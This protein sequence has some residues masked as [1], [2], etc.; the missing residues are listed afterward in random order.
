MNPDDLLEKTARERVRIKLRFLKFAT[1][2][3]LL[4]TGLLFLQWLHPGR[5]FEPLYPLSGLAIA[6]GIHAFST[7]WRLGAG[8]MEARWVQRERSRLARHE[9]RSPH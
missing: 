9:T 2:C 8:S 1:I 5:H 3:L 7:W 6:L 4:S